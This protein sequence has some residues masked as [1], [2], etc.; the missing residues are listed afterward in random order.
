MNRDT[1]FGEFPGDKIAR[2]VLVKTEFGVSMDLAPNR[3]D[4][5]VESNDRFDGFHVVSGPDELETF[6]NSDENSSLDPP[7]ARAFGFSQGFL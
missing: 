4:L 3:T 5:S 7:V 2:A 6:G 1:P